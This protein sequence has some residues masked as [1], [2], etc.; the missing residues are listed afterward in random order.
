MNKKHL[1]ILILYPLC[2]AAVAAY[3]FN[4]K[5]KEELAVRPP[6]AIIDEADFVAKNLKQGASTQDLEA[7]LVRSEQAAQRLTDHG[8]V[9]FRKQQVY[10]APA[11]LE[12][13]P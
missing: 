11:E 10:A 4:A 9:V 6:I 1:V 8:Y 7:L 12:A 2:L 13:V 3:W 5:I